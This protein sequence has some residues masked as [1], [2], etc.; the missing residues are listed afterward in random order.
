VLR[1]YGAYK[2][3]LVETAPRFI[4]T[5]IDLLGAALVDM[6]GAIALRVALADGAICDRERQHIRDYFAE[7]WGIDSLYAAQALAVL[8]S[9]LA[10]ATF[11]EQVATFAG[12]VRANPDCSVRA[13]NERVE[14]LLT[15]LAEADGTVTIAERA[16]IRRVG[17]MLSNPDRVAAAAAIRQSWLGRML[18]SLDQGTS[19]SSAEATRPS[20]PGGV[21]GP[22]CKEA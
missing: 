7:T 1:A 3:T 17:A 2:E 5:P 8:E 18:N 12:F 11:E 14:Q 16:A 15:D 20:E 22:L 13:L 10:K 21:P 4:N 9:N 6:M 19:T